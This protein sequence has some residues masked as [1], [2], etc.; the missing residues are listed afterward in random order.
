MAHLECAGACRAQHTSTGYTGSV[1]EC[2]AS[3]NT[4]NKGTDAVLVFDQNEEHL[5]PCTLIV[6]LPKESGCV[7]MFLG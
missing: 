6:I 2:G 5:G 1:K 3:L 7:E 4:L